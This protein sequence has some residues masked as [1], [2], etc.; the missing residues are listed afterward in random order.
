[1]AKRP[2]GNMHSRMVAILKLVLPLLALGMLSTLFLLSNKISPEDAIPYA[3]IDLEDR[4][5]DPKMTDAGF[6]GVTSDGSAV[7]LGALVA[8]PSPSGGEMDLVHGK[9]AIPDGQNVE[10]VAATAELISAD[11]KIELSGGTEFR[12]SS[13]F[14]LTSQG[15][16]IATERTLVESRGDV[17]AQGPIGQI[18]AEH[19]KL[20]QEVP[21]GPYL[22]V[23]NGKVRLLYQPER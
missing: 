19:M 8:T 12:T 15:L 3:E 20:S 23:F 17:L 10:V 21:D 11:K 18:T 22:L 9:L 13:G 14:F 2:P 7:T 16:A 4:L 1:M 5:K 6:A